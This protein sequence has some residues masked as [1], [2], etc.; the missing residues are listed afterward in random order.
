[1]EANNV[2]EVLLNF[3]ATCICKIITIFSINSYNDCSKLCFST[4][5]VQQYSTWNELESTYCALIKILK[6]SRVLN[7]GNQCVVQGQNCF[8]SICSSWRV[9]LRI[10]LTVRSAWARTKSE[11]TQIWQRLS[12]CFQ[13]LKLLNSNYSSYFTYS[14][15]YSS[16]MDWHIAFVLVALEHWTTYSSSAVS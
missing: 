9:I 16:N 3:C 14:L 5:Y 4:L 13:Y 1:M 8:Y 10:F 6:Q 12:F 11:R 15:K 7:E 2:S